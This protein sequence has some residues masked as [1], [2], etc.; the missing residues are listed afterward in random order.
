MN[1]IVLIL[2]IYGTNVEIKNH[3]KAIILTKKHIPPLILYFTQQHSE[4]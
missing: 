3:T 4:P 1:N 2:L